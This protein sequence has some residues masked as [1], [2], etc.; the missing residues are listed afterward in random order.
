MSEAENRLTINNVE[1]IW[2]EEDGQ[3]YG[4]YQIDGLTYRIWVENEASMEPRLSLMK[5]R[6]LAGASF[7]KLGLEKSSIW[8][9]IIKYIN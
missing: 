2:S 5:D 6:G 1:A 9:I 3:Y 8:D 4:E 7:W